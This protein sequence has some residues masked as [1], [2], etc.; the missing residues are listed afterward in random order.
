MLACPEDIR[1][2]GDTHR[3]GRGRHQIQ[4]DL[5]PYARSASHH[6]VEEIPRQHEISAHRIAELLPADELTDPAAQLA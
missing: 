2:F 5:E 4:E 1:H 6:L 3:P